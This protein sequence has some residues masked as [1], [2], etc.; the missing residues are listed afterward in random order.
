[1]LVVQPGLEH[2]RVDRQRAGVVGD[3]QRGTRLGHVRQPAHPDP[4]PAL[5]ERPG[6]RHQHAAVELGSKPNWSTSDFA[7]ELAARELEDRGQPAA[8]PP[9]ARATPRC[10]ARRTPA[11]PR[12]PPRSASPSRWPSAWPEAGQGHQVDRLAVDRHAGSRLPCGSATNAASSSWRLAH[13]VPFPRA[14]RDR[15]ARPAVHVVPC[16]VPGRCRPLA[17][18]RPTGPRP[19]A[20]AR[21]TSAGRPGAPRYFLFRRWT[22]VFR[23]SLRCFFLAILLRRFLMTE[24]TTPPL[25]DLP[26]P[27]GMPAQ[28][29]CRSAGHTPTVQ[30]T[31]PGVP[32]HPRC[33]RPHQAGGSWHPVATLSWR[34]R[35]SPAGTG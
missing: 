4:E 29:R 11:R 20:G 31:A 2:D 5:V 32:V 24:P 19:A 26:A 17:P 15:P 21:V 8:P 23:S 30:V 22:R 1:M 14:P 35:M 6:D 3:H 13:L 27:T 10:P 18:P 34:R 16:C 28:A 25:L 33:P 12:R 9:S 7:V